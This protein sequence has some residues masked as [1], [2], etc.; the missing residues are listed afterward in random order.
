MVPSSI[1]EPP[2]KEVMVRSI[3][4]QLENNMN[5]AKDNLLT[6]KVSQ[7]FHANRGCAAEEIYAVGNKVML[8][9]LH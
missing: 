9:T 4:S 5:E 7:A 2:N 3:M 8:S 1:V 6:F